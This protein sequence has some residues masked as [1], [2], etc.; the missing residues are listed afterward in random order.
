MEFTQKIRA[1]II[2]ILLPI[3][4]VAFVSVPFTI[5]GGVLVA[6]ADVLLK[7]A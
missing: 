4:S 6:T 2:G 7:S 5:G 1:R 3:F